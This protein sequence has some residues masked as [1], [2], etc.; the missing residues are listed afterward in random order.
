MAVSI[1][2]RILGRRDVAR[3]ERLARA[4]AAVDR[5]LAANLELASVFDQTHQAA[6]FENGEYAR[7]RGVLEGELPEVARD[8]ADVYGRIPDTE[9]AMERRGPAAS[10][11]PEDRSVIEAWEGDAR[12]VQRALRAGADAKPLPLWASLVAWSRGRRPTRR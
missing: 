2:D 12:A 1:L 5:E 11:R 9:G 10:V 8:L 3:G 6:V 4:A 7:H